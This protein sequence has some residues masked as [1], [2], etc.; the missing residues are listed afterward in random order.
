MSLDTTIEDE[1]KNQISQALP[2]HFACSSLTR[3]SGGTANFVYRGLLSDT[4]KSII[5]KHTKEH[6]ASNPNFKIDIQRCHFE[7]AILRSLDSLLPY[8][9]A[10]ITVRTPQLLHFDA[11]ED[12]QIV[13]DLP[14]SVDLKTFL[15]S[16]V[17]NGISKSSA[18][19]L[20]RALG[21]WLRSFHDWG[22]SNDRSECKETLSRNQTMKDLKFWVNYTMLL[23]T[24]KNFPT[25][26]D[27]NRHIFEK[28]HDFAAAE[29]TQKEYDDE[30]GIIH[31]DFWTGK[32]VWNH[33]DL[34]ISS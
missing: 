2:K 20:G 7:E 17:S 10:G 23:D 13:E 4:T 21:S 29:L 3:L 12:I 27:K 28:L 19:A 31:G 9:Q 30:Y 18:R 26:L 5:I 6:S 34:V 1:S 25:I 8:F 14:N 24:V 15:L 33:S 32:Y 22:N 11:K 16:S